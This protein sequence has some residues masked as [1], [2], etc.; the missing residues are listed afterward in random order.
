MRFTGSS[1]GP[2]S[3]HEVQCIGAGKSF[4][5]LDRSGPVTITFTSGSTTQRC[6]VQIVSSSKARLSDPSTA[7]IYRPQYVDMASDKSAALRKQLKIRAGV[8][9]RWVHFGSDNR[10]PPSDSSFFPLSRVLSPFPPYTRVLF[11]SAFRPPPFV[12]HSSKPRTANSG[13]A[14]ILVDTTPPLLSSMFQPSLVPFFS[15]LLSCNRVFT[16]HA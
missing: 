3:T 12:L 14:D 6:L 2:E 13:T 10:I 4:V 8:V 7:L 11:S 1:R 15:R 5:D 9:K 16:L